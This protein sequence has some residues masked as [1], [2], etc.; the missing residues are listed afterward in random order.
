M[1]KCLKSSGNSSDEPETVAEKKT[2]SE[3]ERSKS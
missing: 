1:K 3:D 2:G